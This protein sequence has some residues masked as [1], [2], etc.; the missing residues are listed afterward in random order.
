MSFLRIEL[1]LLNWVNECENYQKDTVQDFQSFSA[2]NMLNLPR[3][4]ISF[5]F[6]TTLRIELPET[7]AQ[8]MLVIMVYLHYLYVTNNCSG[9][10]ITRD[11]RNH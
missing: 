1:I 11:P 9:P 5:W 7:L 3:K 10:K 8:I 4:N 6:G 2:S